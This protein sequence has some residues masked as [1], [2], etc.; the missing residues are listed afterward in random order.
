MCFA[1]NPHRQANSLSSSQPIAFSSFFL[2]TLLRRWVERLAGSFLPL[3][4]LNSQVSVHEMRYFHRQLGTCNYTELKNPTNSSD[5]G[6][7]CSQENTRERFMQSL[8]DFNLSAC[9]SIFHTQKAVCLL[10]T[11]CEVLQ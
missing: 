1:H 3:D 6:A 10:R 11:L 2:F 7:L 9:K 4:K 5:S 8:I